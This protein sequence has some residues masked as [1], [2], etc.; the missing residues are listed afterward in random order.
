MKELQKK[1]PATLFFPKLTQIIFDSSDTKISEVIS[2]HFCFT[3]SFEQA[4]KVEISDNYS[5][6]GINST[7]QL[8]LS[9]PLRKTDNSV[10]ELFENT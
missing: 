8:L 5:S 2:K 7:D 9:F 3:L 10:P 6:T 4:I 1:N